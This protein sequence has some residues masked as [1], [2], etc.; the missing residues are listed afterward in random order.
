MKFVY[1]CV[2]TLVISVIVLSMPLIQTSDI[3]AIEYKLLDVDHPEY[4]RPN[5]LVVQ[6]TRGEAD[7]LYHALACL[8]NHYHHVA[9]AVYYDPY[10]HG[11]Q[12]TTFRNA[13]ADVI[14]A[15]WG[16]F[17]REHPELRRNATTRVTFLNGVRSNAYGGEP[18]VDAAL[19]LI[20]G[21]RIAFW[22]SITPTVDEWPPKDQ[23]MV[24]HSLAVPNDPVEELKT[25]HV[26]MHNE[27]YSWMKP[28][29]KHTSKP[30]SPPQIL[31][32]KTP[33]NPVPAQRKTT[34]ELLRSLH[35]LRR[36]RTDR[37]KRSDS[38]GN[39]STF[40]PLD[41][42]DTTT[43]DEKTHALI[44]NILED[45][46]R[47]QQDHLYSLSLSTRPA[48]ANGRPYYQM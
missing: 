25:W 21:V 4:I 11:A 26:F 22:T 23:Q 44:H 28:V 29:P 45:E 8:T 16:F 36:E 30:S 18:E 20:P 38:A 13:I 7:C 31:L 42:Y 27:H 19:R 6:K 32:P 47:A 14:D 24:L 46:M 1:L 40:V 41:A 43:D 35:D 10:T 48:N 15:D 33:H 37:A 12:V 39:A 2:Q 34:N 9:A 5:M 3:Q 17:A